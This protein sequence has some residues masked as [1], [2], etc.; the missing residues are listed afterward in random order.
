M[1]KAKINKAVKKIKQIRAESEAKKNEPKKATFAYQVSGN[2]EKTLIGLG[3]AAGLALIF[4]ESK[5][6][7]KKPE[8]A[9]NFFQR[10]SRFYKLLGGLLDSTVAQQIK[11]D[12]ERK[13]QDDKL[14]KLEIEDALKFDV[15]K[16]GRE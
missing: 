4:D 3:L 16:A 10:T 6:R 5:K 7:A 1:D 15:K 9:R 2:S 11:I 12:S 13:F 8:K 14:E